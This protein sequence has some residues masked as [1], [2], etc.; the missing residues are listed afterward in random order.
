ML[1]PS[2]ITATDI[3]ERADALI[4]LDVGLE[5]L[6]VVDQR[7]ARLVEYRFFVGLT[8]RETAAL[9]EVSIRTIRRDWA[10]ARGWL[11]NQLTASSIDSV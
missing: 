2:S 5:R 4:A 10:R 1:A 9:L 11:L 3:A 8:E 7:L 6:A